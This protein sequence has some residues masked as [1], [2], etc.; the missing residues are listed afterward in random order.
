VFQFSFLRNGLWLLVLLNCYWKCIFHLN[1]SLITYQI[2]AVLWNYNQ[3]KQGTYKSLGNV[4]P[5]SL[6]IKVKKVKW[7]RYRPGVA[8][9]VRRGMALLFHDRSTRRGWVVSSTL[10]PH[11]NPGKEPVP[12]L[13]EAG[14]A[15]GPVWTGGKSRP[16]RDSIPDRPARS[17]VAILTELPG[18]LFHAH[19]AKK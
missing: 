2:F 17:S 4:F 5:Y 15:S 1:F 11:F 16:H 19:N 3:T 9:R 18:S 6:D 10:R 13:Q 14:W 12:I 7:S 8:Q